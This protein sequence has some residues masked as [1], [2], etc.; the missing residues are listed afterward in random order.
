MDIKPNERLPREERMKGYRAVTWIRNDFPLLGKGTPVCVEVREDSEPL[1]TFKHPLDAVYVF[2]PEDGSVPRTIR[3]HCHRFVHIPAH[4]C[5]NLAAAINVVLFHRMAQL[6]PL[7]PLSEV[8]HET[9]GEIEVG[10]WEGK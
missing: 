5:L 3:L 9:R 8:L 10:G 4:H 1:T 7:L 2:G 6:S